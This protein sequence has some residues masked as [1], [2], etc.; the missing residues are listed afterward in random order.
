MSPVD[1]LGRKLEVN[2]WVAK[3]MRSGNSGALAVGQIIEIVSDDIVKVTVLKRTNYAW[4]DGTR[5][6]RWP[7]ETVVL[8]QDPS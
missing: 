7:V 2:D 4:G 1:V 5:P 3:G 6:S 8:L